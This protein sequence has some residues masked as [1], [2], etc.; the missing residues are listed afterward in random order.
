MTVAQ[1]QEVQPVLPR[2]AVYRVLAQRTGLRVHQVESVF[3]ALAELAT[4]QIEAFRRFE[5]PFL[6][7]FRLDERPPRR[8][9][10]W[11]DRRELPRRQVLK[12]VPVKRL[13]DAFFSTLE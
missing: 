11:G 4:E 6:C 3:Q 2:K 1:E 13:R 8:V 10:C 7:R 5:V 9:V 12:V